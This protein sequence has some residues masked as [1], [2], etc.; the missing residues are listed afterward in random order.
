MEII[1]EDSFAVTNHHPKYDNKF[2]T[3]AVSPSAIIRGKSFLVTGRLIDNQTGLGIPNEPIYIFWEHFDWTEYEA[4]PSGFRDQYLIGQGSTNG[5]GHFTITCS[6]SSHSKSTGSSITVYAVFLGDPFLGP[7]QENRQYTT[8]TI[9]CYAQ[10]F[11]NAQA[12]ETTVREGDSFY[13]LAALYLDNA[14][15]ISDIISA[16][17]GENITIEWLG[18]V[19]EE[20]ITIFGG[21]NATLNVPLGTTVGVYHELKLSF[22]ITKLNLPFVVGDQI[23]Q[24]SQIGTPAADWSNFTTSI[25]VYTGAGVTFDI[26]SPLPSGLGL[27]PKILRGT[28]PIQISGTLTN[29]TGGSFGYPVNLEVDFDSNL[30]KTIATDV[31]GDFST[32]FIINSTAYKVGNHEI[33]VDVASGQG[34]TATYETENVT[35][36]SNSTM[37]AS[38]VNSTTFLPGE[39]V[40]VSGTIRDE[41]NNPD[42]VPYMDLIGQ[43]EGFGS[44]ANATTSSTGAFTIN[45]II[46]ISVNPALENGTIY[47]TSSDTQYF[48]GSNTTY[49]VDVFSSVTFNI[50][51]NQSQISEGIRYTSIGGSD[52]YT[53][54]NFTIYF[55]FTDQFSRPIANRD[56]TINITGVTEIQ[57]T[58]DA[59]GEASLYVIGPLYGI[60]AAVY[61][62]TITINDIPSSSFS[63]ELEFEDPPQPTTSPPP[64][65]GTTPTGGPADL[66]SNLAIGLSVSAVGII[67]IVA[68]VYGFG[69]FRRKGKQLPGE[70]GSQILD[71]STIMKMMAD[72]ERAK[73]YQRAVIL[74]Y[75]A[76][77]VVCIERMGILEA[78]NSTPRELARLVAATNRIPVR[79]I[80]MLVMRFEEA[81]YSE[82]KIRKESYN[83]AKQALENVELAL[84]SEPKLQK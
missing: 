2:T 16:S 80:T 74:V 30:I 46:P 81:R 7:I 54:S 66:F 41:Y 65:N 50:T 4:D 39:A 61:S 34:I 35:I 79:D 68:I 44:I 27:Y 25:F 72:A 56:F 37:T 57:D 69:R 59:N 45:I 29:S 8:D 19:Y 6:D 43:W 24:N 53:N 70:P 3:K 9:D 40:S 12:S 36:V 26:D 67:I 10:A 20:T 82:H 71:Y 78:G 51:L 28:T 32:T 33:T 11:L 38:S 76:F 13:V 60:T 14:S 47:L 52:L 48:T 55:N 42:G 73:D 77:I 62:L 18:S 84:K 75:Q 23:S 5:T 64:T 22:N 21:I 58:T 63:F 1:V 31:A 83:L 49:L 15:D 17:I